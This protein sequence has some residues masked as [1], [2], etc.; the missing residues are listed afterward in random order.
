MC[1]ICG[2]VSFGRPAET[3]VARAM[4]ARLAHRGPDGTG[5][6]S[7]HGVALAH[8][9]LAIIDLS[10]GGRQPFANHDGSLQLLHNGEIFN[11]LELRRELVSLGHRFRSHT[12]TEVVLA[13]YEEWGDDCVQRFNGMWAF[14]LWD[15]RRRRLFCS[16]DRFGIKPL[17]YRWD[18][19]RLVFASEPSALIADPLHSLEPDLDAVRDF[20][21][22]G[23]TDHRAGTFFAGV[24]QLPPGH[25]LILDDGGLRIRRYWQLTPAAAPTDP[26]TA[27]REL[28]VDSVR[29]RLRSDVPLGTALSG[30]LDSSAVAVTIDHLLRTEAAAA[31]PVG[32]RQETFTMYFDDPGSDERPYAAA[33]AREILSR[34]HELT[35]SGEELVGALPAVVEAQGEPFGSTSIVAQWFV[36]RAAARSGLKVMLD[37][38][39][40]D[41][42]LAGYQSTTLSYR[43][44][45]QLTSG[46]FP[47]FVADLR[48]AGLTPRQSL[49]AVV[50][51]F[52]PARAR[53]RLRARRRRNDL[54]VHRQIRTRTWPP[55]TPAGGPFQDRLRTQYHVVL[56]Q[57]GLPELLRYED[58]NTMAHS[59]EGRVPFLDH[60][61]VELLYGL[62]APSLV[63]RGQTKLVLREA[64]ADLLPPEVLVR[65]DKL[66]FVTPEARF[67]RGALGA[68]TRRVLESPTTRRRAFVDVDEA[69]R[70][71]DSGTAGFELWR[72]VSVELWAR[73]F[74]D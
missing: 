54:L 62:P 26:A 72:C 71:L 37:G 49:E 14:V 43:L 64:L 18:G 29:L 33:V 41:E 16:R 47:S 27:F 30:G 4:L 34:P 24:E 7:E 42:T 20:I 45:E 65:R 36:M 3:E 13:A 17:A 10:D 73:R 44:A 23:Y 66:G 51:P 11:Y 38:Q 22:Q 74:L 32:A 12:D 48:G 56:S 68:F 28:F 9:R 46:R 15:A 21:E 63:Y 52:L 60:R 53:W 39:G 1:G 58:R 2:V 57:L 59:L 55:S 25:S 61:L 69:L 67:M 40:G 8:A 70:R 6:Y 5:E 31:R 19:A 50:T 35:F